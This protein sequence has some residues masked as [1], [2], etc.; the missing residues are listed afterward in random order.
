METQK[1]V[2]AHRLQFQQLA[3]RDELRSLQVVKR[4][5]VFEESGIFED[6]FVFDGFAGRLRSLEE[7]EEVF[8]VDGRRVL[9]SLR[10]SLGNALERLLKELGDLHSG[11]ENLDLPFPLFVW[12]EGMEMKEKGGS[13]KRERE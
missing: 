12:L 4:N 8:D 9:L 3:Q 13:K 1:V 11:F 7:G 5:F 10:R 2:G 6:V